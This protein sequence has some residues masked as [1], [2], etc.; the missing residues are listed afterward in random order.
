M[1]PDRASNPGLLTYESGELPIALCDPAN[2]R[3][4]GNRYASFSL[5]TNLNL[6]PQGNGK[7]SIYPFNLIYS[8]QYQL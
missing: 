2:K 3:I 7:N 1:L 5:G 6:I 4:K 8:F